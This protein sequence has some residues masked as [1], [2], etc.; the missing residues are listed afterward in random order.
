MEIPAKGATVRLK[1]V[2]R[3]GRVVDGPNQRGELLVQ[4]A[5]LQI[6]VEPSDLEELTPSE[7]PKKKKEP[8]A[9]GVSIRA[10][11]PQS[12]SLT[13]DLHGMT[14]DEALTQLEQ[15]LDRALLQGCSHLEIIH[16]IGTG[17]LQQAVHSYLKNS[18]H[19]A[20]VILQPGNPGT[21]IAYL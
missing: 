19:V 13:I 12:G 21:S 20:K 2:G 11:M 10:R 4:V 7:L 5:G 1:S 15:L 6:W 16:G 18:R 8:Q 17:I 3:K 9:R 14:R